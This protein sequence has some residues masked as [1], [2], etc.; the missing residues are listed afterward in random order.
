MIQTFKI[1]DNE[2]IHTGRMVRTKRYI[3]EEKAGRFLWPSFATTFSD[4]RSVTVADDM[5][6]AN[7][8]VLPVGDELWALWEGGSAWTLDRA[9]LATLERKILTPDTDGLP[10]SAH[11]RVEQN[12]RIWNFGYM[13]GSNKLI[14]YEL[15]KSGQLQRV[16]IID[17]KNSNLVHDFAITEK[18]L[19]FVLMPVTFH[20]P[21][22]SKPLSFSDQLGWDKHANVEV[23]VV[24][25]NDLTITYRFELPGFFA[26]HFGNAWQDGQ[27]IRVEVATAQPLP[28][29]NENVRRA[30][31]GK[32]FD[33]TIVEQ[34]TMDI[35]L[36][37]K[38][39]TAWIENLPITNGE[40]PGFDQRYAGQRTRTDFSHGATALITLL[41]N[42]CSFHGQAPQRV[43]VGS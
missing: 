2:M 33:M 29:F 10:F 17:A 38:L 40:F 34:T 5:N 23:L 21:A 1:T 43:T 31:T 20:H 4:A 32:P 39:G 41:R 3:A 7:T 42:M 8:S 12:G 22:S 27:Q 19:V 16:E 37:V 30:T 14:I 36:D 15:S 24:D 13:S 28:E 11:P 26:F 9:S 25:K 35:V 6:V 18:Y